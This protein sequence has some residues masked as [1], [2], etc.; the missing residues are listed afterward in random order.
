MA[1]LFAKEPT[2]GFFYDKNPSRQMIQ[3]FDYLVV[4]PNIIH[5]IWV[6]RDSKKL[7]ARVKFNNPKIFKR[8]QAL[9]KQGYRNFFLDFSLNDEK[10]KK[11]KTILQKIRSLYPKAF[12]MTNGSFNILP[13][14]CENSDALVKASLFSQ[15]SHFG[16]YKT[17]SKEDRETLHK[18]FQKAKKCNLQTV[19]VEF[20]DENNQ[21][22]IHKLSKDVQALGHTPFISDNAFL[23]RG[24]GV[25]ETITRDVLCLY[26]STNKSNPDFEDSDTH[27][28]TS[29]PIEYLGYIPRVRDINSGLPKVD[30]TH[31]QAVLIWIDQSKRYNGNFYTWIKSIKDR[32]IPILFM[33]NF[34]FEPTKERLAH[35]GISFKNSS[36]SLYSIKKITDLNEAMNYE[37]ETLV[38]DG[39]LLIHAKESQALYKIQHANGDYSTPL[40]YTK[41]GGFAYNQSLISGYEN[42]NL[43]TANPFIFLNKALQLPFIPVPDVTTENGKRILFTHIDGDGFI[44]PVRFKKDTYSAEHIYNTLLQKYPFPHSI[45]II[46]G[47]IDSSGIRASIHKRLESSARK[48]FRLPHV[49]SSTHTYSHPYKWK[50]VENEKGLN[51][52]IP[53][54]TFNFTKEI[55]LSSEYINQTLKDPKK[56]DNGLL[57]WTGDCMPLTKTL[58]KVERAGL[59]A[60]N[61]GDTTIQKRFPWLGYIAPYGLEREPF[62]QIYTGMQNENVYTNDWTGPFWGFKHVIDTFK[63][64]DKPYRLKPIN[65][66]YHFYSASK[67][68]SFNALKSV[69][70][71]A[72]KQDTLALYTSEYI[73]IVQD[74]YATSISKNDSTFTIKNSG[75]LRTLRIPK[76][77]GYPNFKKSRGIIGFSDSENIRYIHLSGEGAYTLTLQNKPPKQSYL[78]S[79][80]A[81]ISHY[82]QSSTQTHYTLESHMPIKSLWHLNKAC[83][84]KSNPKLTLRSSQD[85]IKLYSNT[86]KKSHVTIS[87]K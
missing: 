18:Q 19:S 22:I 8:I 15:M 57:F 5:S 66:Y 42:D 51:I 79:A 32:G 53:N 10:P 9:S 58:E 52:D 65:I 56:K 61:G 63:L 31:Y 81:R 55:E 37:F 86:I 24:H 45:S 6:F 71:W 23:S 69:Y 17:V 60:I 74:F 87:C 36:D 14:L 28:M 76:E 16:S 41:W 72:S 44:E 29:M 46:Q 78:K 34:G 73:N 67:T 30:K 11:V 3:Q 39:T 43:W 80:N 1:S 82:K 85:G 50:R 64:T 35:F 49:E 27:L 12:I 59:L 38:P 68:S 47:E 26:D 48:I 33:R 21:E 4:D 77:K 2:I 7:L 62:W 20:T 25:E 54:Y 40:A 13:T 75:H 83:K 84:I 70:E